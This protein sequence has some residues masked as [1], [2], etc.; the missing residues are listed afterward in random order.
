MK[1]SIPDIFFNSCFK[2]NNKKK[3]VR[4]EK[5]SYSTKENW[6]TNMLPKKQFNPP[7]PLEKPVPSQG[8]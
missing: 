6:K 8:H 7:F 1:S 3:W 2:N 5:C 4:F